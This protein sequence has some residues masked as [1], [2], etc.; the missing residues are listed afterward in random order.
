M[1]A[2]LVGI[3]FVVALAACLGPRTGTEAD[4]RFL[5][6]GPEAAYVGDE[7][8]AT[9]HEDLYTSYQTHGMAQSF[10]R[11]TPENAVE[12]FSGVAVRHE[13]T[14]FVYVARRDGDRF[15]QEEYRE[16]P[17]GTVSHRLV[18]TMDYV[19][20]SGSAARTYLSEENGRLYQLPLTWYTQATGAG[21]GTTVGPAP[22]EG[23]H[24][25]MSPGYA[26]SNG[27]FG[28]RIPE[29]CMACHNDVSEAVPF[30]DGKYASLADGIGCEQCHGPG[31]LH[32]DARTENPDPADSMDVTIVNP[33]WLATDL[34]LDVCQQCHLNG[35]VSVLREG[36][37]ATSYRPGRPLSAHRAVFGLEGGREGVNVISHADRM[38]E[39]ACFREA[40]AMTCVTCHD[41]HE[42]FRQSGPDYF[43]ATCRTCHEPAPLQAAMPTPA[44][45]EQHAPAAN[46][47]SCHMPKVTAEDA[48]HASFT[49]HKIRVVRNDEVER[50]GG[51]SR[52]VPYFDRD[53]GDSPI[54]GIAYVTYARQGGG[55]AAFRQGLSIL[56]R[57][58]EERPEAGEA[59]LVLGVARLQ[60]GDARGALAPLRRAVELEENPE[61]LNALAQ[62]TE[63][64][65]GA[66]A[67]AERLYRR[68]LA[69]QPAA[70]DVRT[71]L[72]RVLEAQGRVA[73]AVGEYR[74]AIAEEPW[75]AEAHTLLGGAL[76]KAGEADRA[77]AALREAITLDPSQADALTNLAVLLAQRGE[78]TEAGR[79]FRQAVAADPR[80]ANAQA[81]LALYHLN[82]GRLPEALAS[83]QAA[84]QI[85]PQ[86]ATARQ[87]LQILQQAGS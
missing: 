52:L 30:A 3:A 7:T 24:W 18:R 81:N 58:L 23:G 83:A 38:K 80:N 70:A 35:E 79:R 73:E 43:N 67:E 77:I 2:L 41:P 37:T 44:L 33:K 28:R 55:R 12:D 17:D 14:G 19:V 13:P 15:V 49:D 45:R 72:G 34:Q 78:G 84:L 62:A 22:G 53:E 26:E 27:R 9:C 16:A 65:G 29:R 61:R 47:F 6:L 60:M 71:N 59:Q 82:E 51:G 50:V 57:A 40:E 32:V 4:T 20:G 8:C 74:K 39:S 1:R 56:D 54:A 31:S 46:C 36:E 11:L 85:D 63:R 86:Q 5:N 48:P 66:L 75:L 42:G 21:Q 68:A 69:L 87:V 76:A 64:S 10:Y 25:G